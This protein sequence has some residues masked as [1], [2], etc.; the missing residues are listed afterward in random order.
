MSKFESIAPT[1]PYVP[2]TLALLENW[3]I[4]C[5]DNIITVQ[6]AVHRIRHM[7]GFSFVILRTSR[8][9]IQ[10]VADMDH[11]SLEGFCEGCTVE[12]SGFGPCGPEKPGRYTGAEKH[13]TSRHLN[14]YI[15]LDMEMGYITSFEDLMQVETGWLQEM[16]SMLSALYAPELA[17]LK[18][19]LP[20]L[21]NGIPC[22]RFGD[23]KALVEKVFWSH[24]MC[25]NDF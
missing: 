6:G 11:I 9:L 22:I 1:Q 19:R 8:E 13:S 14:E 3:F 15:G 5:P 10:C 7:S 18:A 21:S 12:A 17:L 20:D 25:R 23:A 24:M 2:V 4:T 16:V